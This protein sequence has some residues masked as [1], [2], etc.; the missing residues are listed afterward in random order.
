LAPD[1]AVFSVGRYRVTVVCRLELQVRAW[2]SVDVPNRRPDLKVV[3]GV[4]RRPSP[5]AGQAEPDSAAERL[6]SQIIQ[7]PNG[8]LRKPWLT[9]GRDLP[10]TW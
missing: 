3:D 1:V 7:P 9:L 10:Q 2:S 8:K 6:A 4:G 5:V